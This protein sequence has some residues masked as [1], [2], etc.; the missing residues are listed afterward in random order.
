MPEM[1]RLSAR[2]CSHGVAKSRMSCGG[3]HFFGGK[4]LC[5]CKITAEFERFSILFD[6]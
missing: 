4:S 6:D 5:Q 2:G 1:G 3:P